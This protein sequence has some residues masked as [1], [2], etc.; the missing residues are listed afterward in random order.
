MTNAEVRSL[1]PGTIIREMINGTWGL[2]TVTEVKAQGTC[3]NELSGAFGHQ[4]AQLYSKSAT[5]NGGL[6]YSVH[7]DEY[8][9]GQG[10]P[11]HTPTGE[12]IRGWEIVQ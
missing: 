6:T 2:R 5:G 12:R 11:T 3:T 9:Q 8:S 4:W 7:S 1:Q 10:Y